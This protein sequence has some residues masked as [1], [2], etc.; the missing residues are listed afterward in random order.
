MCRKITGNYRCKQNALVRGRQCQC[1]YF[2]SSSSQL[3]FLYII[4]V[5]CEV[6]R[7]RGRKE[8]REVGIY[9][10]FPV[11]VAAESLFF[12]SYSKDRTAVSNL[13]PLFRLELFRGRW[14][15]FKDTPGRLILNSCISMQMLFWRPERCSDPLSKY[16]R[17]IQRPYHT[18][19]PH[20]I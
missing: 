9:P 1:L 11:F 2:S 18:H 3:C 4:S 17:E 16:I 10:G 7:E 19:Y 15:C 13:S 6:E 14:A 5:L 8:K 12:P 20:T